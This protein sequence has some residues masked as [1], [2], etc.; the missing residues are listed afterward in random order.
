MT[1]PARCVGAPRV[2]RLRISFVLPLANLSGGTRTIA[3]YARALAARGH[4]VTLVSTNRPGPRLRSRLKGLV[5]GRGWAGPPPLGPSHLDGTGLPHRRLPTARPVVDADLPDADVVVA[6]WWITAE[7]VAALSPAKGAKVQ[8]VQGNDAEVVGLPTARVEATWRLPL[9]RVVVSRWLADLARARQAVGEVSYVPN[10]VDTGHFTA[11][12]RGRRAV[13]TVGLVYADTAVKGCDV[14]L[15]AYERARRALPDLRLLVFSS[16]PISPRLPLPPGAAL[17]LQPDQGDIPGLYAA[18]DAWLWPSRSEGFG[19]P[20]LE[21]MACRTPVIAAPAGA[22]P[23]LLA[24]GGG[25]LLPE[26]AA[27][28]M[29]AAIVRICGLPDAEWR[30]L[31]ARARAVAEAHGWERSVDLLEQALQAAAARRA[32]LS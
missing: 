19:L 32:G 20:I 30:A 26:A 27:E 5:L 21:A 13:P 25:V 18:C 7:W 31:S 29:A 1:S 15:E 10:G 22:A 2:T 3:I 16:E 17:H 24:E 6:T 8:L 14:A 28:P 4:R 11:P 12:E 9:H 23:E